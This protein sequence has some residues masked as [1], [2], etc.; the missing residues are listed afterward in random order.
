MSIEYATEGDVLVIRFT[1]GR[2]LDETRI[3]T[4]GDEMIALLDRT[5]HENVLINF[6]KV[7]FMSS[8]M[9]GTL[10]K[11]HKKCKEYKA[12]LKLCDISSDILEVFKITRLNKLFD[13]AK[14]EQT[15]ITAFK[16]KG[17]FR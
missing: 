2:I 10:V 11:F 9:L 5:D 13:I 4:L 17:W 8:A 14:D 15:A 3:R 6:R 16:K 1:E 12:N 7:D